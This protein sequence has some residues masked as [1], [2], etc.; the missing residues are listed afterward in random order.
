M[1]LTRCVLTRRIVG[2]LYFEISIVDYRPALQTISSP[3]GLHSEYS[4]I[5]KKTPFQRKVVSHIFLLPSHIEP[6][7]FLSIQ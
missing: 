2:R 6:P 1:P 4:S 3:I 7:P 5:I